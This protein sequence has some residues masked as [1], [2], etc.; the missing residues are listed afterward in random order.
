[1]AGA[2]TKIID[3]RAMVGA[4][5]TLGGVTKDMSVMLYR[6]SLRDADGNLQK[7]EAYGMHF[8]TRRP[9]RDMKL[10]I[11]GCRSNNLEMVSSHLSAKWCWTNE[12]KEDYYPIIA[13]GVCSE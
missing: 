11:H 12:N 6:C 13:Q 5:T 4:G 9:T 3:G 1:M 7:F 2:V 8:R 10:S